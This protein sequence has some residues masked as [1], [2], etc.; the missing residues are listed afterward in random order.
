[1]KSQDETMG[2]HSIQKRFETHFFQFYDMFP[3]VHVYGERGREAQAVTCSAEC[4]LRRWQNRGAYRHTYPVAI[5]VS[6]CCEHNQNLPR[7]SKCFAYHMTLHEV[8]L[9]LP[10][11]A[12]I[13]TYHLSRRCVETETRRT[14]LPHVLIPVRSQ[15]GAWKQ[16]SHVRRLHANSSKTK[17]VRLSRCWAGQLYTAGGSELQFLLLLWWAE[18]R[19]HCAPALSVLQPPHVQYNAL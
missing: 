18:Q 4:N 14:E 7:F 15:S 11:S 17:V 16:Y 13:S 3:N 2:F 19:G 12:S 1:M 10:I 9:P 6:S 5:L 8:E